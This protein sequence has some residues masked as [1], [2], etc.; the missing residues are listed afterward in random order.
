MTS[1]S[2][3]ICTHIS[4]LRTMRSKPSVLPRFRNSGRTNG[5]SIGGDK[6]RP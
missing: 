6:W 3:P 5:S 2:S 4:G 1:S